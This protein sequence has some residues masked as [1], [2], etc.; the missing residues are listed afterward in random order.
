M[1]RNPNV[2]R[3]RLIR[4]LNLWVPLALLA[5]FIGGR[6]DGR[7]V[8]DDGGEGDLRV[9]AAE[10]RH[11]L[12]GLRLH[13][14]LLALAVLASA[15]AWRSPGREPFREPMVRFRVRGIYMYV[16]AKGL[17]SKHSFSVQTRQGKTGEDYLL[18]WTRSSQIGTVVVMTR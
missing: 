11:E 15:A 8:A 6:V 9:L 17:P 13:L 16:V 2:S 3:W 14:V 10:T 1:S 12:I 4:I 7:A 5:L 18:G